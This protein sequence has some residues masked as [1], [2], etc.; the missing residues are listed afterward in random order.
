MSQLSWNSW[1]V[2]KNSLACPVTIRRP[3]TAYQIIW[4]YVVVGSNL[5]RFL[6]MGFVC[7]KSVWELS[8][9]DY[10]VLIF[11]GRDLNSHW[12]HS[13]VSSAVFR[14]KLSKTASLEEQVI[15]NSEIHREFLNQQNVLLHSWIRRV[16]GTPF[17]TTVYFQ[18][19]KKRDQAAAVKEFTK[20]TCTYIPELCRRKIESF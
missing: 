17:I 6:L 7:I 5:I 9:N 3:G 14:G 10:W 16:Y 15:L 13:Y 2:A 18:K 8:Q 20:R 12:K 19:Y 11:W 4:S 1:F